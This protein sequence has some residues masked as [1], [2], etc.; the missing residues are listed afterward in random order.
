[1]NNAGRRAVVHVRGLR[2]VVPPHM[3]ANDGKHVAIIEHFG[4]GRTW[5]TATNSMKKGGFVS[6][7]AEQ[8]R[9]NRKQFEGGHSGG[10]SSFSLTRRLM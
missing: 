8:K 4:Q 7:S 3:L 10:K 2:K 1:M 5:T 6:L 9:G